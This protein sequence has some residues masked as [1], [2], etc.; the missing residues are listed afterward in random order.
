M[1]KLI[2]RIGLA[3]ALAGCLWSPGSWAD[4]PQASTD[5][6]IR[7]RI[8]LVLSGGGARGIAHIGVLKILEELQ[9]PI[10]C[11][12]G[13]SMGAIVGGLYAS[14]MTALQIDATMRSLD[15]QEA[16][17]D[18]PPRRD[19]AFRRKQDDRNFL[20]RLPLG[21]KHGQILLPKGFIQ[22]QKLQET[23]RQLTLP[24]SNSTDFDLLPT[25]FRAVAT[26][27]ETGDAV[28]MAKGDLAIAMR[29]S[30]SAPGVF[31]P[32]ELNGRLLVDG[33]LAE[34][35]P[36]NV[37]RAMHADVL[38]V[39]DVSFPLQPRSAL[40]SALS[41]SNQMLAI[42]VRKDSDHQRASLSPRD[43]LIE[44]NLGSSTA[45]DF[46][47]PTAVI[48]RGENAARDAAAQ[49]SA[50]GVGETA[51]RDYLARRATREPGLPV[52][53]FVRVD[54]QSKRYEKTIR[55]E[56]QPLVGKPLDLDQVG[57][58]VTELYGL[59]NFETLDY[60]LADQGEG[61]TRESGLEVRARR[62]SWGPNYLRFGLNIE[63]DFQG[64]SR[65][66]AAARFVLT[67]INELGAELL[68]DVQIGSDPKVVSEFYQPLDASR[69][70]FV[71][72]SARIEARDLGVY[73]KN[74]E[75]ADFRDREVEADL[76]VGR[77]LGN[78]GEI[79]WGLHR[80]NGL[81]HVRFGDAALVTQQYNNGEYFFKF[82]YDRLDNVHFP[83]DG[84]TFNV[85]WEGNRNN[86]GADVAS[87]RVQA[88]WLMARSRGR[89][90]LLIWT[91]AGS[92]LDGDYKP[93]DLPE[94]YSLGGFFN[95]S[96]LAPNS[97]IGPHYAIAR[98]LYFRKIGRGGEGFF[99]FPAYIGM[100]L[101]A[102]NT[103]E[104]R[105]DISFRS[106]RKDA[107][108]FVAFDTFLGPVYL[109]SG[110]DEV[111]SAG[112]YLFLGRTF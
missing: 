6:A 30:M 17:R 33:G 21:L 55:A 61:A 15:W 60:T 108:V 62:K 31:S 72:P 99:E 77:N 86:L 27:L 112:F 51:Y 50:Y 107:S 93:T 1:G 106:A 53:K 54:Q 75:V 7:P 34:N 78:W 24:F 56:M 40:D 89:N 35:L 80:T 11:I 14:G 46:T 18:A 44:P 111:G 19:L 41:I 2:L 76:D 73:T 59:G 48:A 109:G 5:P 70:W 22:G 87:D 3:S 36:V 69:T 92:I 74:L 98:A 47:A 68:T 4:A 88:D 90:T 97:L 81:T 49:L 63:D 28:V 23:L 79:R 104:H 103:W 67:E 64:N 10:D 83:R 13:T 42:L 66:N 110:Y 20:V 52:I 9:I 43:I 58:R 94:F 91:S 71:A 85:Q 100:S 57:K 37:A 105:G 26:D 65:Y 102:G 45:T 32:V 96:G 12:A 82:S 101:E 16:F 8:C 39:S 95:L 38:I 84:Q 29:A 25:P